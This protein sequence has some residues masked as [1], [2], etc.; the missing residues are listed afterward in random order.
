[1]RDQASRNEQIMRAFKLIAILNI[2]GLGL[3]LTAQGELRHH[4]QPRLFANKT[5]SVLASG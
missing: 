2:W 1:M 4:K 3:G 5:R